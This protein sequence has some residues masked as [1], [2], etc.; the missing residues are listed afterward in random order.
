MNIIWYSLKR[1]LKSLKHVESSTVWFGVY[2]TNYTGFLGIYNT[3]P[4]VIQ[5]C[6]KMIYTSDYGLLNRENDDKPWDFG[7]FFYAVCPT[8]G[9][10]N[11]PL[12]SNLSS[13]YI[14]EPIQDW[15]DSGGW[16]SHWPTWYWL[17]I[18]HLA[19]QGWWVCAFGWNI[20]D[21]FSNSVVHFL[22]ARFGM[23]VAQVKNG[24]KSPYVIPRSLAVWDW[25][26]SVIDT[27]ESAKIRALVL[28]THCFI[29][30]NNVF[31]LNPSILMVRFPHCFI[32]KTH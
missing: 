17:C 25:Q 31:I 22:L 32:G 7:W 21:F 5:L 28:L 18:V 6:L 9:L 29:G 27:V 15:S 14:W 26:E 12:G 13:K 3:H 4:Y 16:S 8:F 2:Q 10:I 30:K 19:R 1:T 11:K 20:T 24:G 23:L